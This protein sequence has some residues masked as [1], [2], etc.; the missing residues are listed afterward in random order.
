VAAVEPVLIG[1]IFAETAD[2]CFESTVCRTTGQC[3]FVGTPFALEFLKECVMSLVRL[4]GFATLPCGCVVSRYR[5]LATNREVAYVEEKGQGCDSHAHR[6]NHTIQAG[7]ASV[8][9]FPHHMA[10][11]KAS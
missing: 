4:L 10:A 2:Y 5:E 11:A 6:R 1:A 9:V 7:G 8:A 3:G